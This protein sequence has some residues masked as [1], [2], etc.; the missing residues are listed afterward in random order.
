MEWKPLSPAACISGFNRAERNALEQAEPELPAVAAEVAAEVTAEV[1]MYIAS[2]GRAVLPAAAEL[3]PPGL[4]AAATA[5][6]RHALLA[7]YALNISDPRKT[8]YTDARALLEKVRA[9]E[10]TVD[11]SADSLTPSPAYFGRKS[12][13]FTLHRPGI[14]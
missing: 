4:L 13:A 9:G 3:L 12:K 10:I 5:L 11:D 8:A 6:L 1:R 14:M 7:R 2:G